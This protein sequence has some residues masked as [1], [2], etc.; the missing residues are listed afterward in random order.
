MSDAA[1]D[2]DA[3][4]NADEAKPAPTIVAAT[5]NTERQLLLLQLLIKATMMKV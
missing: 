5:L 1:R 2:E 4:A 3:D